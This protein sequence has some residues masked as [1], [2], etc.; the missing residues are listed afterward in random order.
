MPIWKQM[1][2]AAGVLVA[3]LGIWVSFVPAALPLLERVGLLGPMQQIG[4]ARGTGEAAPAP[5]RGGMPG[6]PAT[7]I[8][9]PIAQAQLNDRISAIG[10]GQ[11]IRSVVILPEVSGR[12]T[13]VAVASGDRVESG[14]VIARIDSAAEQIALERAELVLADA[15]ATATRLERLQSSG[16]ATEIQI[17]DAALAVQNA[18]LGLRQAEFDLSRRT[19]T[20][21]IAGWTGLINI[22]PGSQV[23]ASTEI[24]RIDDRSSLLIDFRVPERVVG[25]IGP[26]DIVTATPLA[27]PGLELEG[28]ISAVDNRVDQAT[29]SLRVQ[30]AVENAGDALRAGMAFSIQLEFEGEDFPA[31][32]PLSI[33]WGSEGAFVWA[34]RDGQAQRVPVQIMQ[35]SAD[36]V[37]VRGA[38]E[39]G[40]I[41]IR[42]GVTNLRPGAEVQVANPGQAPEQAPGQARSPQP[43][44]EG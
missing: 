12:I 41:V 13:E 39:D 27:R 10:T 17:R 40:E 4:L 6:G 1:L 18:E 42:E 29:R 16:T 24:T 32:D 34:V 43:P 25:Q 36:A 38:L 19:L 28:V 20:A 2:L 14:Q 35:R 44:T 26:G 33:Q 37:L 15:Q 5:Q 22:E 7:V 8:A 30:A 21:P 9:E 11:A 23:S 31:V 3:A